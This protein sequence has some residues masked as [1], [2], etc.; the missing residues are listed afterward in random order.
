MASQPFEGGGFAD[1]YK[2]KHNND[3]VCIKVIR[4]FE[5]RDQ[6]QVLKVSDFLP[7]SDVSPIADVGL[8]TNEKAYV[9]EIVLWSHMSHEN[10][11]PFYGLYALDESAQ[12]ICLVSPLMRNGNLRVFLQNNPKTPRLPLVILQLTLPFAM[13]VKYSF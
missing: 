8:R 3:E 2:G 5:S 11:L 7:H 12:R 10:I 6:A 9:R 1:V 4:I 13:T